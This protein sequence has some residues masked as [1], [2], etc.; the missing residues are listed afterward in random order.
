[1]K[2]KWIKLLGAMIVVLLITTDIQ[3]QEAKPVNIIFQE[4]SRSAFQADYKHPKKLMEMTITDRLKKAGIEK[5]RKVNGF[6][7]YEGVQ[8]S[9]IS[10]NK[11]DIYMKLQGK[12]A[13]PSLVMMV[14]LGYDNFIDSNKDPVI[15]ANTIS[16]LNKLSN[17]A[18]D[19]QAA[20]DLA[21]QQKA[22]KKAED[23]LRKAEEKRMRLQQQMTNE[24][25][26][27]AAA[28]KK[29][30]E[31]RLRLENLKGQNDIISR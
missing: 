17:D 5:Y 13:T 10:E 21:A 14:S 30:E 4:I 9:D 12:K 18:L 28:A 19:M 16:F 7:K 22:L 29:V 15:T 27:K 26:E 31:E 6:K 23:K 2:N 3:A 20:I 1:M 25:K 8:L 24:A 11:I